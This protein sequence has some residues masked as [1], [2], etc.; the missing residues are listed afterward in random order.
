MSTVIIP[1][2]GAVNRNHTVA[3]QEAHIEGS[4][5]SVV[6]PVVLW[7]QVEGTPKMIAFARLSFGGPLGVAVAVGVGVRVGVGAQV[8]VGVGVQVGVGVG[9]LVGVGV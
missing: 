7:V 4:P 6:A 2:E 5:A 3:P 1:E 9:V 8:G